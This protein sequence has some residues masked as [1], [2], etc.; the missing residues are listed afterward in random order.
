MTGI[1]YQFVTQRET[2]LKVTNKIVLRQTTR[3]TAHYSGL[4]CIR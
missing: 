1:L 2:L 3:G 4:L